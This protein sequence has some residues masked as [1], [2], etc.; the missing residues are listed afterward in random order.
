[1]ENKYKLQGSNLKF[2]YLATSRPYPHI[3]WAVYKMY[4][5]HN[6]FHSMKKYL[7][8]KGVIFP[9]LKSIFWHLSMTKDKMGENERFLAMDDFLKPYL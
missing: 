8:Q 6:H 4:I 9:N 2:S 7:L 1:M 3:Y 5:K